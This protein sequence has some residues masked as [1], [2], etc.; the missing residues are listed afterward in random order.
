MRITNNMI[1]HNT[2]SNINGNKINVDKMNNQMSSEKKIQRPS[3]DP[4]IAIRS[5]RL[6]SALSE[7]NQYYTRNIPDAESW[8]EVTETAITNMEKTVAAVRDQCVAG[9]NDPLTDEDR[10][11]ILEQM[12]KLRE[13]AYAEGNADYAGRSVFT[14]FHTDQKLTFMTE[15]KKTQYEITQKL[16]YK[17][18]EE[19]RYHSGDVTMPTTANEVENNPISDPDEAVFQRLRLSYNKVD[20]NITINYTQPGVDGATGQPVVNE[21]ALTPTVYERYSDWA[22]ANGGTYAIPDG[23]AVF[24]QETG[25]LIFS[26][27][28]AASL[29]GDKSEITIEYSKTGFSKGEVRPEYYYDC[30]NVTDPANPITY[31]KFDENGKEIYQDI[32]YRISGSQ[33]L[34]V[35]TSASDVFDANLGRDMDEMIIAVERGINAAKKVSDLKEMAKMEEY[36]SPE[37]QAKL[38]KWIAAAEKESAYADANIQKLYNSYI[39]KCDTYLNKINLALTTVGTKGDT[40]E[41]VKGR[42]ANEKTSMEGLLSTNEDR[43][44]SDIIIDYTAAYNAYQA[45]LQAGAKVNQNTLLNYI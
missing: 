9:T 33:T 31:T 7:I 8:L 30:K 15:D 45:S 29:K 18:I 11:T 40:L 21:V 22:A 24:I 42:M 28:L 43:E 35:N 41:L 6:R 44:L 39:G 26:D 17:N 3:E 1:L 23:E 12:N 32:N 20:A 10:S 38:K 2:S 19:F 27:S 13:Q 36:S 5:L 34:N 25:E 16:S 14:G 4:V 37:S